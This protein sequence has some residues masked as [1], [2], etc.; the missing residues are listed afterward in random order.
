MVLP[1]FDGAYATLVLTNQLNGI[2]SSIFIGGTILSGFASFSLAQTVRGSK[3]EKIKK[4]IK[5]GIVFFS[6]LLISTILSKSVSVIVDI[7]R[8]KFF[9]AVSITL[10]AI[11]INDI[12]LPS[13]VNKVLNPSFLM[14]I[15]FVVS[16]DSTKF[17]LILVINKDLMIYSSIAGFTALL[18]T[19]LGILVNYRAKQG[20]YLN[21][22]ASVVLILISIRILI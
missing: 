13:K 7:E 15:G 14:L 18:V 4:G 20:K 2:V 12:D 1:L 6:F 19:G 9:S 3:K 21:Y 16:L 10:V 22:L 17:D 8:L 5:V 11:R